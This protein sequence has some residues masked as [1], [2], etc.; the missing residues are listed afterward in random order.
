[1]NTEDIPKSCGN[2]RSLEE[3]NAPEEINKR[4]VLRSA[5]KTKSNLSLKSE[6]KKIK[7]TQNVQNN[8][9]RLCLK[10]MRKFQNNKPAKKNLNKE[11][12]GKNGEKKKSPKEK[13]YL[14]F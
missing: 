7:Q 5:N 4:N 6:L 14:F 1:M 10:R 8:R 3:Y 12:K 9:A 13:V 11:K 2:E